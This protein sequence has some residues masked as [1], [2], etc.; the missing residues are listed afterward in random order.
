MNVDAVRIVRRRL[1][2]FAGGHAVTAEVLDA[3]PNEARRQIDVRDDARIASIVARARNA[4]ARGVQDREWIERARVLRE[5]VSVRLDHRR[6]DVRRNRDLRRRRE[7]KRRAEVNRQTT[8]RQREN[9]VDLYRLSVAECLAVVVPL[10]RSIR[11]NVRI[12]NRVRREIQRIQSSDAEA[13][14][15]G[16]DDKILLSKS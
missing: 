10:G 3:T 2:R 13:A 15:G 7:T 16:R 14:T 12:A 5:V 11:R 4:E 9:R 6:E 8:G 1:T